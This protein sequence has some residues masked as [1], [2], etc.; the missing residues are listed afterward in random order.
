VEN[1]GQLMDIALRQQDALSEL[2]GD[3]GDHVAPD[4][5]ERLKRNLTRLWQS[6]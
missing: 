5:Q 2:V 4:P 1:E 6:V 3:A